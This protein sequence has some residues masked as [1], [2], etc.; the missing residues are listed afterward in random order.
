[1]WNV[2]TH[3]HRDHSTDWYWTLGL[4]ALVGAAASVYFGNILLAVI[5]VVGIGSIGFL[6]VRGPREHSVR[7]D[8]RGISIDGTLYPYPIVQSFWIDE[9]PNV[10]TGDDMARLLLT[11]N[12]ILTPHIS[13]PL[14]GAEH[15]ASVREYLRQYVE[16]QEIKPRFGEN[17]AEMLGL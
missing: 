10:R 16:E 5:L 7:I 11:T 15:A 1:M 8:K 9:T 14:D 2:V 3:E 6:S 13:L 17:I 4:V 12:N